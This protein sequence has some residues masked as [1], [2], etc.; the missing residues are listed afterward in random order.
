MKPSTRN[1]QRI[2]EYEREIE[3]IL[4]EGRRS[5]GK[6]IQTRSTVQKQTN[7]QSGAEA[8]RARMIARM[9][10]QSRFGDHD[11]DAE[12]KREKMIA[13][14]Q[15]PKRND[16]ADD[17]YERRERL[18]REHCAEYVT[19]LDD[20]Q[21]NEILDLAVG[22]VFAAMPSLNELT[23]IDFFGLFSMAESGVSEDGKYFYW[24]DPEGGPDIRAIVV[25][26]EAI[27]RGGS[28]MEFLILHELG[29]AVLDT[30]YYERHPEDDAEH[31]PIFEDVLSV[32]IE[33]FNSHWGSD[34]GDVVNEG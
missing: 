28:Y 7:E 17:D 15:R 24:E 21:A 18:A 9:N 22:R 26:T 31:G 29:H 23:E 30:D 14:M 8:A 6:E 4:G 27:E 13:R 10:V 12:S 1:R 25:A 19:L 3:K 34:G 16:A 5:N 32:L 20:Q 2:A 11:S 33:R